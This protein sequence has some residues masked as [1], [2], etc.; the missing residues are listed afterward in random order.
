MKLVFDIEANGLLDTVHTVW[1]LIAHDLETDTR[2]KFCEFLGLP[3]VDEGL[4]LMY[5]ADEIIGHNIIGYD[6]EALLKVKG[7]KPNP[8]TVIKDTL[9]MSQALDYKRFSNGKHNLATWGQ[10]FGIEKPEHEDWSQASLD[11]L[12]RCN[13]DVSI[14]VKAY[15]QLI[16]E[17][18][19]VY[20]RKPGIKLS[21]RNEHRVQQ[22]VTVAERGGWRFD[23]ESAHGV[24]E[25]IKEEMN[26]IEALL[27]PMLKMVVKP[28]D[29]G[30]KEPKWIKNGNYAVA[31]AKWF[32]IPVEMGREELPPILGSYSRIEF[33]KPD[34]GSIDSVKGLLDSLGWVPDDWNWEK[35][36]NA[37]VKKSPKLTTSS[38]EPLGEI[39]M[40][41]DKYYTL[42]SRYS[43]VEGL[44]N[45]ID[46]NGRVHGT[47]FTIATPTSRARHNG[48][49]NIPGADALYGKRIRSL[50]IASEGYKVIG[51]DSSGN[52]MRASKAYVK[53]CEF[54]ES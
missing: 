40:M 50:F 9:L 17:F 46:S 32:D 22:F 3:S 5:S 25:D 39:G 31:T 20:T 24:M 36:G 16:K 52:Q 13:E 1:M 4:E 34:L 11:M 38:L 48:I 43:I 49:V 45:S 6:L 41:V 18:K 26:V 27:V 42:R 53:L 51:A 15:Y 29:T 47:C 7:W 37:F 14:N 2:Y 54:G 33:I 44:V 30:P 12:H 10:Y 23:L 19:K 28:K 8:K 21:L 35:V